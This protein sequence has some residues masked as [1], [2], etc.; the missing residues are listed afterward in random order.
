MALNLQQAVHVESNSADSF[1]TSSNLMHHTATQCNTL[2]HTA[3]RCNTLQHTATPSTSS[4]LMHDS[5]CQR[6]DANIST[7]KC[8][9]FEYYPII[10]DVILLNAAVYIF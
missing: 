6:L 8:M 1:M 3:T 7:F 2:Q 5:L 10:R 9:H 4:N